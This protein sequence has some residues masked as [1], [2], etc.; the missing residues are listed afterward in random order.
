MKRLV[1]VRRQPVVRTP[2]IALEVV[3]QFK[4]FAESDNTFGLR[5][6]QVMDRKH[7]GTQFCELAIM[8][9]RL[10]LVRAGEAGHLM[11]R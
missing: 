7:A 10:G 2:V 6:S 1:L 8:T 3:G 5:N 9:E 11:R 4:F